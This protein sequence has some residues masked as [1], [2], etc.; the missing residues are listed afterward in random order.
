MFNSESN[1]KKLLHW[2][3][4]ERAGLVPRLHQLKDNVG[5]ILA[6]FTWQGFPLEDVDVF[7]HLF[8]AGCTLRGRIDL[9]R[10]GATWRREERTLRQHSQL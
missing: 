2:Q 8:S 9:V 1:E 10:I 4:L 7:C 5:L 3:V 6:L